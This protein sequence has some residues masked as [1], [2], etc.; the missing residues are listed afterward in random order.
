VDGLLQASML[1]QGFVQYC[2]CFGDSGACSTC[3]GKLHECCYEEYRA[4]AR[5]SL[6]G[7]RHRRVVWDPTPPDAQLQVL[8]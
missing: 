2:S 4:R 5:S 3:S 1:V 7:V 8:E 6:V